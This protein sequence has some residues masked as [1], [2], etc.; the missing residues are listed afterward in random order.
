MGESFDLVGSWSSEW[1]LTKF[2]VPTDASGISQGREDSE[3]EE[4]SSEDFQSELS[5]ADLDLIQHRY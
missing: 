5:E 3:S 4:F 2:E 1:E